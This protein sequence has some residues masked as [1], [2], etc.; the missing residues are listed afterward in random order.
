MG[1]G[2]LRQNSDFRL[3]PNRAASISD[4]SY[5]ENYKGYY[6]DEMVTFRMEDTGITCDDTEVEVVGSRSFS[7]GAV[8]FKAVLPIDPQDCED[9]DCH[10]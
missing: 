6:R 9:D 7:T 4:V 5:G 10:P 3:G 2:K 1:P 8:A